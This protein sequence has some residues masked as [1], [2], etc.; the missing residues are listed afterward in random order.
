[1]G[2]PLVKQ[3]GCGVLKGMGFS[4]GQGLNIRG[5]DYTPASGHSG[6]GSQGIWP[7]RESTGANKEEERGSER[8]GEVRSS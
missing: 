4:G 3:E 6:S 2:K 8:G 7:G 5:L 1:M